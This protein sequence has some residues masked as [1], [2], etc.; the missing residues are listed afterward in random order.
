VK[1]CIRPDEILL[2]KR[3]I[4]SSGRNTPKG[5]ITE[6]SDRGATVKLKVDAGR[7]FAVM[8]TKKS[9]LDM[10]PGVGSKVYI[11]FKASAVHL[12]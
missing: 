4:R 11:T 3:P 2:S 6:I 1:V 7:E 8:I 5:K 9:F 10:K 12:I